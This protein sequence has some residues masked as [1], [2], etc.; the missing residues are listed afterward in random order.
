MIVSVIVACARNGVI[1]Q[2]NQLP[3]RLPNDLKHFKKL[4][5]GHPV[6]MGRKTHESI[7]RPLPG[8]RNIVVS[9]NPE[10]SSE[11]VEVFGSM[12]EAMKACLG[13][14]EVY[15][16]GGGS[17]YQKAF[18]LDLVDRLYLTIV[19]SEVE[20]DTIFNWPRGREWMKVKEEK[21]SADEK[22]DHPYTFITLEKRS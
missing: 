20:G 14:D 15:I 19:E 9:R 11:G 6:I 7:G 17:I 21:F 16:I 10:Y 4:T 12:G 1:G 18:D 8:R 22:H 13:V 3:W 5:H 2:N